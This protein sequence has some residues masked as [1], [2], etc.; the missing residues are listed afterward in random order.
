MFAEGNWWPQSSY[1]AAVPN[2]FGTRDQFRG[3]QFFHES[4]CEGMVSGWFKCVTF[5]V[6]FV[7]VKVTQSFVTFC[8][9]MD[10]SLPGSSVHGILQ[11]RI[12]KWVAIP[13]SRGSSQPRNRTQISHIAGRFFTILATRKV[14]LCTLFLFLLHQLHF[15]SSGIRSLRT[16]AIKHSKKKSRVE[17][18]WLQF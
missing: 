3:R 13:F 6:C 16:P 11:A 10:C 15:R 17:P 1:K 2:L 8:N 9:P 18:K 4:G 12:L 14:W 5:I 7:K